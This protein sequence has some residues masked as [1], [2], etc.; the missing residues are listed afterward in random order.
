MMLFAALH[1]SACGPFAANAG[2]KKIGGDWSNSGHTDTYGL[3]RN[4]ASDPCR[5][6]ILHRSSEKNGDNA[7]GSVAI[8]NGRRG[9]SMAR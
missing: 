8:L 2:V 5:K 6:W 4:D 3:A 7:A 1:E 9:R